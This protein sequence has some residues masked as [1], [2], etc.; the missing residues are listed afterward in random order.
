[1]AAAAIPA[2]VV[3][4]SAAAAVAGAGVAAYG[5]HQQGV[6]ASAAAEANAEI[7]EQQAQ[8]ARDQAVMERRRAVIEAENFAREARRRQG[9]RV[10]QISASGVTLSGSAADV[11]MDAALE[12]SLTR[13][14]ILHEGEQRAHAR[15]VG[16]SI[17]SMSSAEAL[18]HAAA[19]RQAGSTRAAATLI[20]GFGQTGFQASQSPAFRRVGGGTV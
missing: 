20:G 2:W 4:A 5:Q 3:Y 19:E 10:S 7:A 8:Q 17:E 11:L 12:D 18:R 14:T 1:M 6:A 13:A 15:L 9:V 16:A